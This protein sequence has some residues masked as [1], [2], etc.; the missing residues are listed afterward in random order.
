M[1]VIS[2]QTQAGIFS[3]ALLAIC[4]Q[5]DRKTDI[6]M[7]NETLMSTLGINFTMLLVE[8]PEWCALGSLL[9]TPRR[10]VCWVDTTA[11]QLEADLVRLC[12]LKQARKGQV[13]VHIRL[14]RQGMSSSDFFRLAA[15]TVGASQHLHDAGHQLQPFKTLVSSVC[16][17]VR[18]G[19]TA[20][21][22][23]CSGTS[24]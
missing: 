22:G 9:H 6:A 14:Q 19:Q 15:G 7:V 17:D 3:V 5:H 23:G 13:D 2:M 18:Q 24:G 16:A 11:A 8:V 20:L 1:P 12:L 10:L 21:G 4:K